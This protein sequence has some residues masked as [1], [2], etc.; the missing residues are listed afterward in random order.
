M[1]D[2]HGEGPVQA[3]ASRSAGQLIRRILSRVAIGL[4][5]VAVVALVLLRWQQLLWGR[6]EVAALALLLISALWIFLWGRDQR[7]PW[8]IE[9]RVG[10]SVGIIPVLVIAPALRPGL[11]P[12]QSIWG[13]LW[14]TAATLAVTSAVTFGR[15]ALIICLSRGKRSRLSRPEVWEAS[16]GL[17][18]A[19]LTYFTIAGVCYSRPL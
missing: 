7:T 19:V 11:P 2:Q 9:V 1:S 16:L 18:L 6:L 5:V 15:P 17:A 4:S 13:L 8:A 14:A 12:G 10:F 3:E